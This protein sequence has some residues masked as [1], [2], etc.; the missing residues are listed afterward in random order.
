MVVD[1]AEK[2]RANGWKQGAV[3]LPERLPEGVLDDFNL[4][5]HALLYV[6][7]H[8]CDLVQPDFQ[9]EP[10]VEVLVIE[11]ITTIDGNYTH[12]KNSR[13]L[14]FSI[15]E[16][17][18]Q[19]SCHDRHRL[20]RKMFA[21]IAPS[22]AHPV[23]P[24]LCALISEWMSKR[25]TRAAFPDAFNRRLSCERKFIRK[26]FQEHGECFDQILIRCE[27][28]REELFDDQ[29]YRVAV[30]LVLDDSQR[31]GLDTFAVQKSV[32]EFEQTLNGCRG[33]ELLDCRAVEESQVTLAHLRFFSPWDFDDLTFKETLS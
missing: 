1:D 30:W 9:K 20:D 23:N 18:F 13:L 24:I 16:G 29:D 26:F 6:L 31:S 3:L 11:S 32:V 21:Q 22:E 27:P 8:D 12:G 25:Y 15:G 33:I 7:T 14:H 2:I 10:H 17:A 4:P 19:A 28:G 5:E